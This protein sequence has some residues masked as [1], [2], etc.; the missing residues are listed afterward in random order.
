MARRLAATTPVVVVTAGRSGH[1]VPAGH[2]VRRTRVPRRALDEMLRQSGVIRVDSQHQLLD[3]AQLLA[4]QPLPTGRRVAVL[5]GSGALAALTAEAASSAGLTV[6]DQRAILPGGGHGPDDLAR[7]EDQLA[8]V[9][10]DGHC[11]AVSWCTC[12]PWGSRTRGSPRPSRGSAAAGAP[13]IAVILGLSAA[14]PGADRA[15]DAD[16]A[17]AHRAGLRHPEDAVAALAAATRYAA[18]RAADHGQ[19]LAP[20]GWTGRGPA[21]WWPT[22]SSGWCS[23]RVATRSPWS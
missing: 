17:P 12:R 19:P 18:W 10:S 15:E 7:L 1:V 13:T 21:P 6:G 11:D 16:G 23:A 14:D 22:P 5:A 9:Y 20:S 4:S 8:E 2:A 3:V